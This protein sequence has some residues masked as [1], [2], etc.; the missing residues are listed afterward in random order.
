MKTLLAIVVGLVL[1][2]SFVTARGV[3]SPQVKKVKGRFEL[4]QDVKAGATVLQAGR[5]E[6]ASAGSSLTFRKLVQDPNYRDQW[7]YDMKEKPVVVPC[8][9][10]ALPA[11]SQGTKV[12]VDGTGVAVLKSLT[13]DGTNV[14]FTFAE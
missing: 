8:T 10:T 9:A 2:G 12:Q 14:T 3:Q 6:V 4:S 11:K 1:A 5:Y 13:L 7:N